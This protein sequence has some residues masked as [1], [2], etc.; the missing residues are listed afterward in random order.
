M[1]SKASTSPQWGDEPWTYGES[2][3]DTHFPLPWLDR[4]AAAR[5]LPQT[6]S[7]RALFAPD[8]RTPGRPDAWSGKSTPI[9]STIVCR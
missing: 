9:D 4:A 8:A 5:V 1:S 6:E 3:D 2:E 7:L